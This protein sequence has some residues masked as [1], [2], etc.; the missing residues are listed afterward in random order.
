MLRA[1]LQ[2]LFEI[3]VQLTQNW[4]HLINPNSD[5][6]LMEIKEDEK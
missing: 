4:E 3:I 6:R 2:P 1:I 5:C